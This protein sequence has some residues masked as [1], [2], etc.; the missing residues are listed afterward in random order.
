MKLDLSRLAAGPVCD[1]IVPVALLSKPTPIS[2]KCAVALLSSSPKG[3]LALAWR[4]AMPA[5]DWL[6]SG[7][8]EVSTTVLSGGE[9]TGSR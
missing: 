6:L 8:S 9:L 1:G 3:L 7:L 4:R 2:T 5:L